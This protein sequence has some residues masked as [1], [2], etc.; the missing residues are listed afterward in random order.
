MTL[1]R[2]VWAALFA[3][4]AATIGM[5]LVVPILRP[6]S[7]DLSASPSETLLLVSVYLVACGGAMPFTGMVSS[8]LGIRRSLI[9]ALLVNVACGLVATTA[10][11]IGWVIVSRAGWGLG[12][13]L[14]LATVLV[15]VLEEAGGSSGRAV[16]LF[17]AAVGVGIAAGPLAG[18]L[19]GAISWRIAFLGSSSMMLVAALSLVV[20]MPPNRDERSPTRF[21]STF[22]ALRDPVVLTLSVA[23]LLYNAGF[24]MMFTYTPFPLA[25]SP[26]VVGLVYCGW[27]VTLVLSST[28]I[29]PPLQR[30]F[31]TVATFAGA[32]VGFALLLAAMSFLAGSGPA[33]AAGVVCSGLLLGICNTMMT[34]AVMS[35]S[36]SD[37][38]TT[39]A[40]YNLMRNAGPAL[41]PWLAG[42]LGETYN[43]HVPFAVAAAA[44]GA[45]GLAALF[46]LGRR[47]PAPIPLIGIMP[48]SGRCAG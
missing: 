30:R 26:E 13:A 24:L 4:V 8:R 38:A 44:A 14:F 11:D 23:A 6:M 21:S 18:G 31:G 5:G 19:L 40:A 45:A 35:S 43:A 25:Q 37:H 32:T 46:V 9:A 48:G 28:V 22:R 17:E 47:S 20:L 3:L 36:S 34:E 12:S 16:K 2:S 33:L 27:G 39:S 29:G 10:Q 7:V 42:H 15:A 1:P 41:A